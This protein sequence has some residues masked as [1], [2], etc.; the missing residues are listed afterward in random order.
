MEDNKITYYFY[1]LKDITIPGLESQFDRRLCFRSTSVVFKDTGLDVF[2]EPSRFNADNL[3]VCKTYCIEIEAKDSRVYRYYSI[4]SFEL[5]E[6][7][8]MYLVRLFG[9]PISMD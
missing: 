4:K 6:I 7:D 5:E 8:K 3:D 9:Y 1:K 2:V